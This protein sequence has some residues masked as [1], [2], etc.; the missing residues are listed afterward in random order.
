M[1]KLKEESKLYAELSRKYDDRNGEGVSLEF[2]NE[3]VNIAVKADIREIK[4]VLFNLKCLY[5]END[6]GFEKVDV[7]T[8]IIK[9]LAG[10]NMKASFIITVL[11]T[12]L[13]EGER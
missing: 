13:E 4:F 2:F 10:N 11:E 1:G 3:C 12:A 7:L 9:L 6:T 8:K 5:E